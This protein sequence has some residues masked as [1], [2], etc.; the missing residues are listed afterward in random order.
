MLLAVQVWAL[1]APTVPGPDTGLPGQ[2]KI[3]H[4]LLFAAPAW[5]A[6]TLLP[7][8]PAARWVLMALI[9]HALISEPIQGWL[10]TA[11]LAD[12]WDTVANL[13]GIS[14]GWAIAARWP[15]TGRE[16]GVRGQNGGAR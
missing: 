15:V 12:P 11:R 2:D 9:A 10:T 6:R 3:G 8:W 16:G 7:R 5:V 1:Y 4:L 14:L 13:V